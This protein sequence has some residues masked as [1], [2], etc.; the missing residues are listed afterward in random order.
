MIDSKQ[1][2]QQEEESKKKE[3]SDV[4][5]EILKAACQDVSDEERNYQNTAYTKDARKVEYQMQ[6]RTYV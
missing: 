4:F 2:R 3:K 1:Q 5:G 6:Q